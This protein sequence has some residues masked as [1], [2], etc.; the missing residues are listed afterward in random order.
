MDTG[1]KNNDYENHKSKTRPRTRTTSNKLGL[2]AMKGSS[3]IVNVI[4]HQFDVFLQSYPCKS[5]TY[6]A[7]HGIIRHFDML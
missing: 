3:L 2:C 7:K 1:L 4:F 5:V 6:F